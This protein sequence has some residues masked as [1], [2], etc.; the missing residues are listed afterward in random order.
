M[1]GGREKREGKS[2]RN[3]KRE[4]WYKVCYWGVYILKCV[5]C[6][7]H[8]SSG[9]I[10]N[11]L[12]IP[13]FQLGLRRSPVQSESNMDSQQMGGICKPRG[14]EVGRESAS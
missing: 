4:Y 12:K 6:C 13:A 3:K 5:F 14:M 1:R 8:H 9:V 10:T 2:R 7:C 11:M